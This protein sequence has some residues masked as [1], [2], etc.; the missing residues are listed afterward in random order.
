MEAGGEE[1]PIQEAPI[2]ELLRRE[3]S[4]KRVPPSERACATGTLCTRQ[5]AGAAD[6]STMADVS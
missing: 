3:P 2:Q 6:G 1:A 5:G 4:L